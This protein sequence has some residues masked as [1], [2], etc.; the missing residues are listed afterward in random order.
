LNFHKLSQPTFLNND[1]KIQEI[2]EKVEKNRFKNQTASIVKSP[3]TT[4]SAQEFMSRRNR[5]SKALP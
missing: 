1:K 5:M 3:L 2:K 4:E